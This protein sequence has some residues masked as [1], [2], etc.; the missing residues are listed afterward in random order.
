VTTYLFIDGAYLRRNYAECVRPWFG[1]DG[2]IDFR[3]VKGAFGAER[4]FYYDALDDRQRQ[5]ENAQEYEVRIAHDKVFFDKIQELDGYFVRLGSLGGRDN[6]QQKKVDILLA[7]EALDHA[8][9]RNMDRAI[10]L[11][12]DR[13]FEPLV[14]SLVQLGIRVEVVGDKKNTSPYLRHA[15]DTY[16]RLSLDNYLNWTIGSIRGRFPTTMIRQ[17]NALIRPEMDAF[18][19]GSLGEKNVTVLRQPFDSGHMYYIHVDGF[20]DSGDSL[21]LESVDLEKLRLY[22]ELQ[23]GEIKWRQNRDN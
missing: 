4:A 16:K 15:A 17:I 20:Y 10:L 9:R 18:E 6:R 8:V 13:D 23:H 1:S 12:G 19:N 22:F 3:E 14:H 2:E 7:V 5:G 21:L 11:S